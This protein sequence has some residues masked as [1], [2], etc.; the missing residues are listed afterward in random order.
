MDAP[1][2][3]QPN[4]TDMGD[5]RTI[6]FAGRCV[7]CDARY[8]SLLMRLPSGKVVGDAITP[9]VFQEAREATFAAFDAAFRELGKACPRCK[10]SACPDCW[11]GDQTL[12]GAC[13]A[14]AGFERAPHHGLLTVGPL[15][16]GRLERIEP[17][18]YSEPARPAWLRSLVDT[19]PALDP[20]PIA[21]ASA[22]D[23]TSPAS[24]APAGQLGAPRPASALSAGPASGSPPMPLASREQAAAPSRTGAGAPG[25]AIGVA[26]L[27]AERVAAHPAVRATGIIL[28]LFVLLVVGVLVAAAVSPEFNAFVLRYVHINPRALFAQ[29]AWLIQQVGRLLH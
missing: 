15:A 13:V 10:R 23:S 9:D 11:D 2:G 14:E 27:P 12:C 28:T 16:D 5:D 29:I 6:R 25:S 1:R 19:K 21:G 3:W 26:Q 8:A 4:Y 7:V 20:F 22:L 18:R 17:G 24:A